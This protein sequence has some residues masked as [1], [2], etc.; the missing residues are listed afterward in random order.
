MSTQC[1]RLMCAD[2]VLT[3]FWHFFLLLLF[4]HLL[5]F[6]KGPNHSLEFVQYIDIAFYHYPVYMYICT[7]IIK[8]NKIELIKQLVFK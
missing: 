2:D 1:Q 6:S 8:P 3:L 4:C 7:E 5:I